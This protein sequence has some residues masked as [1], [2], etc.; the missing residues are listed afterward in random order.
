V[1]L[2]L[3]GDVHEANPVDNRF[4][5]P[6]LTILGAGA[7]GATDRP[8][9][10]PGLYQ[11]IELRPGDGPGGFDRARVYTRAREKVNGPWDGWYH[12]PAADGG[13]GRVANFDVDLKPGGPRKGTARSASD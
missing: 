7:F 8:E 1:R 6:G 10:T 13:A 5:W 2:V 9:S 12:W 3:H 11:V 4:R